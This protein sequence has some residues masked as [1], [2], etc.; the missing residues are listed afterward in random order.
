MTATKKKRLSEEE[1]ATAKDSLAAGIPLEQIATSLETSVLNL[2]KKLEL[3]KTR[4][5][6]KEKVEAAVSK[7]GNGN[8]TD[9]PGLKKQLKQA[10]VQFQDLSEYPADRSGFFEEQAKATERIADCL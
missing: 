4:K 3:V 1:I 2:K 5:E 9:V 10:V 7:N 6:K 8:Q